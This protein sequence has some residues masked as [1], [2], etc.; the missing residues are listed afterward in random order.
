MN[1]KDYIAP[2]IKATKV[3]L[4]QILATSDD[5]INVPANDPEEEVNA[6]EALVR[7]YN[8]WDDEW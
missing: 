5:Q 7:P 3:L 6:G 8:V 2:K 4:T 1:R